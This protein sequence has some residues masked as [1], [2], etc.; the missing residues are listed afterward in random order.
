MKK[1]KPPIK[2]FIARKSK[3]VHL[4]IR[5]KVSGRDQYGNQFEDHIETQNVGSSGGSF[6]TKWEIRVGSTLK[7]TGPKGFVSLVR[8]VWVKEDYKA[9]RRMVGFQLLEPRKDWV[10]QSQSRTA[11]LAGARVPKKG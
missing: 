2:N 4:K 3:R 5:F 11:P 6:A 9:V 8:V 10:L 1:E 7:L